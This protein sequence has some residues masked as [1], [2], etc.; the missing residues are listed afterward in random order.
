[1]SSR[2]VGESIVDLIISETMKLKHLAG[3]L[4]ALLL[5][6][7]IG[8]A[9]ESYSFSIC[10]VEVTSENVNALDKIDGVTVRD[11]GISLTPRRIIR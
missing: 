6:S 10:G 1:M 9:Q 5:V 11:G 2:I 8:E 3:V 7:E 4:L